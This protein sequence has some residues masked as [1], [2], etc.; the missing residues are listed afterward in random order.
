MT[1]PQGLSMRH[2]P[3]GSFRG[4]P[5]AALRTRRHRDWMRASQRRTASESQCLAGGPPLDARGLPSNRRRWS[6]ATVTVHRSEMG[7]GI[8]PAS[9][10]RSPTTSKLTGAKSMSNRPSV[11]RRSTAARTPTVQQRQDFL[12]P[13]ARSGR[14]RARNAGDGCGAAVAG[15]GLRGQRAESPGRAHAGSGPHA[16]LRRARRGRAHTARTAARSLGSRR[17]A[18]F[19]YLGKEMPGIDLLDMTTGRARYGIVPAPERNEVRR[20]R[21][22]AG[23]WRD[24]REGGCAGGARGARRGADRT[25]SI[26]RRHHPGCTMG[27]VAVIAT[28][29]WA[30]IQGRRRPQGHLAQWSEP[31]LRIRDLSYGARAVGSPVRQRRTEAGECRTGLAGRRGAVSASYYIPHLAH[32]QMEP[33]SASR[34]VQD[35]HC[36][37]WAPTQIAAGSPRRGGQTLGARRDNVRVNV[38]LLGGAFGRKSFPDFIIEAALLSRAV[39][40]AGQGHVDPRR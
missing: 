7:Q 16:G 11:T 15:A 22:P 18:E 6:S 29:T 17:R 2:R 26:P 4:W 30:A 3:R 25:G 20:D 39:E 34:D 23:V 13:N 32:A 1:A 21:A 9:Q 35:G 36:E 12:L 28:S 31:E 40:H 27:G 37:I 10:W 38:T 8:R 24:C 19:R 33:V 5:R 14:H